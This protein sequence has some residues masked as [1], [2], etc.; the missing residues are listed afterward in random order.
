MRSCRCLS[1]FTA[2]FLSMILRNTFSLLVPK[3]PSASVLL[4]LSMMSN[5]T[6]RIACTDLQSFLQQHK[7]YPSNHIVIGNE[8]GDA[9]SVISAITWAYVKSTLSMNA[10]T[11]VTPLVSITRH[12]LESQRPETLLLLRLAGVSVDSLLYVN[13]PLITGEQEKQLQVSLVDHNKL[14]LPLHNFQVVEILD[15]HADLG[16]HMDA[17]TRSIAFQDNAA[18]VASTCTL[19]AEH[20]K[21]FPASLSILLLGVILLDSVNML[22]A[23]G[24]GTLRDQKAIDTLLQQ[25]QWSDLA[26]DA[27]A[28]L[29]LDENHGVPDTTALFNALQDAKF[30]PAFW[31]SLSVR[32]TLR[33]DYKRFEAS[34]GASFGS[35]SILISLQDFCSKDDVQGSILAFME[36]RNLQWLFLLFNHIQ[37][38]TPRRKLMVCT[39]SDGMDDVVAFLLQQDVLQLDRRDDSRLTT[40]SKFRTFDQGNPKASRKQVAPIILDYFENR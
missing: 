33:L 35:S 12:D 40:S 6:K 22:P 11:G 18:T 20:C 24:K 3:I 36:E 39:T 7:R 30:D 27:Q 10:G 25:T 8:A 37:G 38:G 4:R 31:N 5:P 2:L 9:D 16:A 29:R 32:D 15:H 34:S 13:N 28:T 1:H 14:T 26:A 17:P 21:S 23:A 19:V